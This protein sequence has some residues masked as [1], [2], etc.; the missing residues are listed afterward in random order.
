M[1]E[2]SDEGR[3][4]LYLIRHG[5]V[6]GAASGNLLGRTDT[7]LSKRGLEQAVK[8]AQLLS[9]AQLSAV[10]CSDLQRA[11]VTAEIIAKRSNV[12]VQES[13]AWREIH[14][15]EWEGRTIASLHH[16]APQLVAQLFD[17]P[18]SFEYPGG[19]SFTCFT[20]RVL[21][22]VDQL[23][24]M[25]SNGE[26]VL[27]VHGGVCRTIIGSSLGIPAKNWLRLSQD[28]GCLNVIDWYDGNPLLQLLNHTFRLSPS[29][30][31]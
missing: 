11:R 14:M 10:Y 16:E 12:K 30:T 25:H 15:G 19:E 24:M 29:L 4:R 6:E 23:L 7:P 28:Y 20:G 17:D 31:T 8:L 5:E 18:S 22:A 21:N 13:A 3:L 1:N 27:V 2:T 9:T 26:V